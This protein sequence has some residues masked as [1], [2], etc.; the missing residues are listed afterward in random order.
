MESWYLAYV[1][2]ASLL[3][4]ALSRSNRAVRS[5]CHGLI[6][7]LSFALCLGLAMQVVGLDS[8]QPALLMLSVC[9]VS[10]S[11]ALQPSTGRHK[12]DDKLREVEGMS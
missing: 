9:R 8:D 2:Y 6:L 4:T 12:T 10:P 1:L 7:S 3:W 5:P 11:N